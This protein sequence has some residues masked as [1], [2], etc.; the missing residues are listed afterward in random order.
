M[1]VDALLTMVFC[2]EVS[3]ILG[4]WLDY[5]HAVHMEFMATR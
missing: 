3:K 1:F 5:L 4:G 2:D